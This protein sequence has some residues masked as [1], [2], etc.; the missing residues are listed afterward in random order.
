MYR[1][2]VEL[3][4]R[5]FTQG[6]GNLKYFRMC[7]GR[8]HL[9]KKEKPNGSL[10]SHLFLQVCTMRNEDLRYKNV[11]VVYTRQRKILNVF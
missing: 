3:S 9:S 1:F 2:C 8:K 7:R 10:E 6:K 11:E 5:L 4:K